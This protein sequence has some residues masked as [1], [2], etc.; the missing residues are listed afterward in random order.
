MGVQTYCTEKVPSMMIGD[1][2]PGTGISTVVM[3]FGGMV[4]L[5]AKLPFIGATAHALLQQVSQSVSQ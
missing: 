3:I 2:I 1:A 4:Q 5:R